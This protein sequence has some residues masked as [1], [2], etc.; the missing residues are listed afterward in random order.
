MMR[1]VLANLLKISVVLLLG[2][3]V[4]ALSA[5]KPPGSD[6]DDSTGGS[7]KPTPPHNVSL[8]LTAGASQVGSG[9]VVTYHL[10]NTGSDSVSGIE[11]G[12]SDT[13][14]V[15][16]TRSSAAV[17][18]KNHCSAQPLAAGQACTFSVTAKATDPSCKVIVSARVAN[19][20]KA[21]QT[22]TILRPQLT[23]VP[24]DLLVGFESQLPLSLQMARQHAQQHQ[25]VTLV[26][27][28]HRT[29]F[30]KNTSAV[31][32][33]QL[34]IKLPYVAGVTE[35]KKST[36]LAGQALG[37]L[38]T[39]TV[40]LDGSLTQF[41]SGSDNLSVSG[42]NADTVN[43]LITGS[44]ASSYLSLSRN[45]HV[46]MTQGLDEEIPL[47]AHNS[48]SEPLTQLTQVMTPVDSTFV[49]SPQ[50]NC[51]DQLAGQSSCRA[52]VHFTSGKLGRAQARLTSFVY[53]NTPQQ[54]EEAA[55]VLLTSN[56]YPDFFDS[57]NLSNQLGSNAVNEVTVSNHTLYAATL[58][59]LSISHDLGKHWVNATTANGLVSNVAFDVAV[60]GKVI[61]LATDFGLSLSLDGGESWKTINTQQGLPSD[62]C[63]S[64]VI[65][66][67]T[68]FVGTGKGLAKSED[69]GESWQVV[70]ALGT[71]P[72]ISIKVFDGA[73]FLVTPAKLWVSENQGMSW[74]SFGSAQG[75]TLSGLQDVSASNQIWAVASLQGV[76]VS[77]DLGQHWHI[78]K[79]QDGLGSDEVNAVSIV[80]ESIFAGTSQGLSISQDKGQHWLTQ[81]TQQGLGLNEVVGVTVDHGTVFAATRGGLAMRAEA[82]KFFHNV[83][84]GAS[85]PQTDLRDVVV[86]SDGTVYAAT[87]L[88]IG[89][90]R[91]GG[92]TWIIKTSSDGL[93]G[94]DVLALA[95]E[96]NTVY[97]AINQ[98]AQQGDGGLSFSTDS[99]KTWHSV[100]KQQGLSLRD[101]SSVWVSG[102]TVLVGTD[103]GLGMSIDGGQHF[104]MHNVGL[105]TEVSDV[106]IHN[107][108]YYVSTD[109]GVAISSDQGKSWQHLTSGSGL[110]GDYVHRFRVINSTWFVSTDQGLSISSN[111][112]RSWQTVTMNNGLGSNNVYRVQAV[113]NTLYAGTEGGLSIST[114]NGKSWTNQTMKN[115]LSGNNIGSVAQ[116]NNLLFVA[117]DNGL[118]FKGKA[119]IQDD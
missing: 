53:G 80:G 111:Q 65:L 30:I 91:D 60:S 76:A 35:D 18:T 110:A 71:A 89:V 112:G 57:A 87:D 51:G 20:V 27:G 48:A 113:G 114:D 100:G 92:L 79:Q 17:I 47:T 36:C 34:A 64:V 14:S 15:T 68:L 107:N 78:K 45:S 23:I 49:K 90:S 55:G 94:N 50:N 98:G 32:V 16:A 58:A 24:S 108:T 7:P 31:P 10:Q 84:I 46:V 22:L 25:T 3:S 109:F 44:N 21:Q 12:V 95:T 40:T 88:G 106:F 52:N 102:K 72:I 39:C 6:D 70:S 115:G 9:G 83:T 96:G 66:G 38:Q 1:V 116:G 43:Q 74:R 118:S 59:G 19:T 2:V 41:P 117:T 56:T 73:L 75:L 82:D 8:Q 85:L 93:A 77:T 104:T 5:C 13:A 33:Q 69:W 11:L 97:A 81:T 86:A 54:G 103:H 99:G 63:N 42:S 4:L 61:A 28:A 29:L 67:S 119:V 101:D 37:A 62:G 105:G 26:P